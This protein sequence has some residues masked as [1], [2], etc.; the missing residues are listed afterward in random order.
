MIVHEEKLRTQEGG[1]FGWV[2]DEFVS[3]SVCQQLIMLGRPTLKPS[4][5]LEPQ[6][7]SYRTSSNTFLHY[8]EG[9]KPVDDVAKLVTDLIE[10]PIENCEGM[11]LVHYKPGQYYKEHH[12]YFQEGSSYW[13]REIGRGGLRTWT[14]FLYLNDVK[15]GGETGFPELGIN[16]PPKKGDVVV[17]HNTLANVADTHPKINPR[18]LHGG[19]PVI[20]GEKWMVNLW[21][22]ENLR[23]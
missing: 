14:A 11:Q 22:R 17:F 1:V 4:T 9:M 5:T 8:N 18:S 7:E 19:M 13:D 23:Y 3:R 20:K 6:R 12:D 16:I 15:E 2:V 21:F 10:V